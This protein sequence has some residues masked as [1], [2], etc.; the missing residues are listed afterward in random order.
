MSNRVGTKIP[1]PQDIEK[2]VEDLAS[3]QRRI[4]DWSVSL[5]NNERRR[6]AKFRPA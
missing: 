3:V 2:L 1:S 5:S 4:L 6:T